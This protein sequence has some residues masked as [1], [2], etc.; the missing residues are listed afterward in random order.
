[1]F[2]TFSRSLG[3][4][5]LLCCLPLSWLPDPDGVLPRTPKT[6]TGWGELLQKYFARGDR[7]CQRPNPKRSAAP[8]LDFWSV[9]V[10]SPK[11]WRATCRFNESNINSPLKYFSHH[12]SEQICPLLGPRHVRTKAMTVS[13]AGIA[14]RFWYRLGFTG[15]I[16]QATAVYT[17]TMLSCSRARSTA[18]LHGHAASTRKRWRSVMRNAEFDV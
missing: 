17:V 18:A 10:C 3:A 5:N 11:F 13:E 15:T 6:V 12:L 8:T 4:Q 2:C 7:Y 1:M 14:C 16:E 9:P